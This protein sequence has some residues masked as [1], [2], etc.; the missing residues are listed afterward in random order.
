[1]CTEVSGGWS[2][3]QS[4]WQR[5]TY[6]CEYKYNEYSR[7]AHTC[8]HIHVLL[9]YL[10]HTHTHTHMQLHWMACNGRTE[11]LVSVLE[12][13][14]YVDVEVRGITMWCMISL[15]RINRSP[16][17]VVILVT[18]SHLHGLWVYYNNTVPKCLPIA[19]VSTCVSK[20]PRLVYYMCSHCWCALCI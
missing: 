4:P 15:V 16:F 12:S 8:T 9:Y 3:Y 14:E 18:R 17:I 2:R 5:G 7:Y 20:P 1:M 19:C 6:S 10:P 11:L 13:G